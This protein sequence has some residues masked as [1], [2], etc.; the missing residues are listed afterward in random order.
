MIHAALISNE[1]MIGHPRLHPLVPRSQ[2]S[3]AA[4]QAPAAFSNRDPLAKALALVLGISYQSLSPW[5]LVLVF[6][7]GRN[8]SRGES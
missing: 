3:W 7:L 4:G 2:G 5:T 1:N 8:A 6:R